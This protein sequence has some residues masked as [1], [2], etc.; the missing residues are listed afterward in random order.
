MRNSKI[1]PVFNSQPSSCDRAAFTMH[2][3]RQTC[4]R[5]IFLCTC[6]FSGLSAGAQLNAEFTS[7]VRQGCSPL[8]VNFTNQS[9]GS[10]ASY[11]WKF[12]NSN[13]SIVTDP[14]ASYILPGNYNVT[15]IAYGSSGQV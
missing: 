2:E 8:V 13:T 1:F 9:T 7:N 10:P 5:I 15:L 3:Q 12:G 14:T 6:I 4:L 11:R